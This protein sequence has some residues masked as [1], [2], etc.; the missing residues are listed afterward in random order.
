M[1]LKKVELMKEF[2]KVAQYKTYKN[3]LY[4]C[5]LAINN[6]KM[7]LRKQFHLH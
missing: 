6:L 5:K 2:C 1:N 3:Q 7:K 4:F